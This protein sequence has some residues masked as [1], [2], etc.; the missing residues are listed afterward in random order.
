MR[1]LA[2]DDRRDL[3]RGRGLLLR[4]RLHR[5]AVG[6]GVERLLQL[7][8]E[9]LVRAVRRGELRLERLDH[10]QLRRLLLHERADELLQWVEAHQPAQV[11]LGPIARDRDHPLL[12][13][14]LGTD[15]RRL[16]P[17]RRRSSGRFRRLQ[18]GRRGRDWR[19]RPGKPAL[20]P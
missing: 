7:R 8:L 6:L 1:V 18:L 11:E 4:Q 10:G 9:R 14:L 12:R 2:R 17:R 13:R 20:G 19:L 15:G 5:R 16:R 3:L